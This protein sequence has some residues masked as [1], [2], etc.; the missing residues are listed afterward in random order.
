MTN[1][2]IYLQHI[3]DSICQIEE[4]IQGMDYE[5]F[6]GAKLVPDAVGVDKKQQ[7]VVE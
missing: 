3:F 7:G 5:D 2:R 6:Y 4:Y 1:D